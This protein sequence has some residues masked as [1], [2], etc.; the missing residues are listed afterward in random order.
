MF[1]TDTIIV[2]LIHNGFMILGGIKN[3]VIIQNSIFHHNSATKSGGFLFVVNLG[4]VSMTNS[5]IQHNEAKEVGGA[6]GGVNSYIDLTGK[7]QCWQFLTCFNFIFHF[8]Q[9]LI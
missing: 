7:L 8:S 9:G 4:L 3:N 1:I 6:I 5:Y 2:Y